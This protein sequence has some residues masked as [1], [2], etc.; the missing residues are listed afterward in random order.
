MLRS[1]AAAAAI[2]FAP[3]AMAY[4]MSVVLETTG[5]IQSTNGGPQYG[6]AGDPYSLRY[7]IYFDSSELFYGEEVLTGNMTLEWTAGN[8]PT[9]VFGNEASG[10]FIMA[11]SAKPDAEG[12]SH[13]RVDALVTQ[14]SYNPNNGYT[15][16][17]QYAY[18]DAAWRAGTYTPQPVFSNQ[19]LTFG[20]GFEIDHHLSINSIVDIQLN[21]TQQTLVIAVPEP[22]TYA[23]FLAGACL[24]GVALRRRAGG[25]AVTNA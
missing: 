21:P 4:P 6:V 17:I 16:F 3:A 24:V 11:L 19:T 22:Q 25:N 1:I 2:A 12:F 9:R 15:Q 7:S 23:M 5:I 20:P 14:L 13:L 10:D 8:L 18:F